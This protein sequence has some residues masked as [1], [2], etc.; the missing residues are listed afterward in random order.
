MSTMGLLGLKCMLKVCDGYK[1][2]LDTDRDGSF[3]STNGAR[4]IS[5]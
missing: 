4:P 2:G 5:C 1:D 3:V